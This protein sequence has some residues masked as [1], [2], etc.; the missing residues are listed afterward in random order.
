MDLYWIVAHLRRG[1]FVYSDRIYDECL[2]NWNLNS[3]GNGM[4]A[5]RL[6]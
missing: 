2:L 6:E 4:F 5:N 3:D 1:V